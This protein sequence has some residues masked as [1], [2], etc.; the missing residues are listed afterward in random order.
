LI[1]RWKDPG[2]FGTV[3]LEVVVSVL[4]GFFGGRWLDGRFGTTPW[5]AVIGLAFGVATAGRFL[6]RAAKRMQ[7]QTE[8]DGFRQSEVDRPGLET[9]RPKRKDK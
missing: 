2:G 5:M 6:Y 3:G 4:I 8:K 1:V 7:R 9:R